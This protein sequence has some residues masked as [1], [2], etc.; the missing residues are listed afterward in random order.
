MNKIQERVLWVELINFD[1]QKSDL[2]V[3]EYL[4]GLGFVPTK[5][6]VFMWGMDF[7]NLHDSE[8]ENCEFPHGI[9]SYLDLEFVEPKYKGKPFTKLELKQLIKEFHKHGVKVLFSIFPCSLNNKYHDEWIFEHLELKITTNKTFCWGYPILNPLKRFKDGSFYE[10]FAIQ[11]AVEVLEDYNFD[12]WHLADGYN[13]PWFQLCHGDYSDDM[14]EQFLAFSKVTFSPEFAQACGDNIDKIDARSHYIWHDFRREWIDFYSYR[15]EVYLQKIVNAVHKAKRLVTSNTCWARDPVEAKY[16]Y[17]MDYN[18]ISKIGI[19]EFV[20]ET[21]GAGGEM[22]DYICRARFSVPFFN[23]VNATILLSKACSPEA[24]FLFNNCI[25]DITEGWSTLHYSSAFLEKEIYKY[26]NLYSYNST[27]K[28][29]RIF[30]GLQCCLATSIKPTEWQYLKSKWDFSLINGVKGVSGITLV[31]GE[32]ILDKELDFYLKTRKSL[33][34]NILYRL[35]AHQVD[36]NSVIALKDINK[37]STPLLIINPGLLSE[38]EQTK[39]LS[40]KNNT[41]FAIGEMGKLQKGESTFSDFESE[42]SAEFRVYG[43][44][45]ETSFETQKL[46]EEDLGDDLYLI[47]EPPSFFDEQF[48][49]RISDKFYQFISKTMMNECEQ[50]IKISSDNTPDS[51][52]FQISSLKLQNGVWRYFI[53]NDNFQYIIGNIL[54]KNE[55]EYVE[56][57]NKFRGRPIKLSPSEE[58]NYLYQTQVRIPP[59]GV[60]VL[61]IKFKKE[62]KK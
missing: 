45:I 40:Y 28:A 60:G 7:L 4:A 24:K 21:C 34:A 9:G 12:G 19:D 20:I 18:R 47:K 29:E 17:G 51:K 42:N 36:I 14:V 43:K 54:V 56:I 61:D 26:S 31:Y 5:I 48:Y 2:G 62:L 57:A 53:C 49:R 15:N 30:E 25:Q 39:L 46:E 50:L 38:A 52:Y 58:P 10:D 8:V 35:L 32:N 44:K 11:K 33:N 16:R 37:I 1:N 3:G 55:V 59:K 41:I 27:G 6:S 22:L 23:V 13:H